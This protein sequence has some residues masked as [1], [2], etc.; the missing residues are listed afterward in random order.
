L[1]I[2]TESVLEAAGS[3]WNFLPFR[4]GLVGG[5]FIGVD[6]FY[7][8]HKA[9]AIG[10][11]PEF[12]LAGRRL[13]NS[14]GAYVLAQ[15]VKDMAKKQIQVEGDRVLVMCLAFK[16]NRPDLLN[17]RTID[18]VSELKDYNFVVDV[19]NPWVSNEDALREYGITPVSDH[20]AGSYDAI[21]LAVAYSQFKEMESVAIRILGKET[22]V[23][24]DLKYI[25]TAQEVDIIL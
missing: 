2:D 10:Y 11:H 16:E 6:P 20:L 22:S 19:L 9:Q 17:T 24:Y 15:L 4:L 25:L 18:I 12:I 3:K 21:I 5:H 13:N 7:L 23:I 14:M 1:C 8:T